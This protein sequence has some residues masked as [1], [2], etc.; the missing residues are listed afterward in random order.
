M[1]LFLLCVVTR[2]RRD[3]QTHGGGFRGEGRLG[4]LCQLCRLETK[5][6]TNDLRVA[7]LWEAQRRLE[8]SITTGLKSL[9]LHVSLEQA[10]RAPDSSITNLIASHPHTTPRQVTTHTGRTAH[11]RAHSPSLFRPCYQPLSHHLCAASRHRCVRAT[12]PKFGN[13]NPAPRF[14]REKLIL[15]VSGGLRGVHC[16]A[17]QAQR[18]HRGGLLPEHSPPEPQHQAC[19]CVAPR[20]AMQRVLN[21]RTCRGVTSRSTSAH[22]DA[23]DTYTREGLTYSQVIALGRVSP[24]GTRG[25]QA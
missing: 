5:L 2:L 17:G 23:H 4:K 15:H 25:C 24:R 1:S 12:S 19:R 6:P 3:T 7:T 21:V 16:Q 14:R 8:Y 10:L 13:R 9:T 22:R 18:H 11:T 20:G